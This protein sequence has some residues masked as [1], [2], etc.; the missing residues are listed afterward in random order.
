MKYIYHHLG[1]GDHIINNGMVRH[2]YKEYGAITLF[3]YKHNVKNVQYM[4]RDLQNFQ[5][6][7][8]ESDYQAD[9]YISKND[10]DCLKIGFSDLS[11]VMPELPF[12]KAF[13]KLAGLDFS[14]R[15]DEFYFE[16]DLE[17]EKEVLN[18]LNPTGEKFVF[19]HDDSDRG[20]SIDMNKVKTDYKIVMNDKRFN[21][22]DYI[23]LIEN[24]EE[25][26]FMQ[27]SFKELMCSYK[28]EKPTL[29]QHNYVRNYGPEMNSTGLNPF[30]EV[31]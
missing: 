1:L 31:E 11:D 15:F 14:V 8:I 28:L 29:Y 23:T 2:F 19:V 22:F 4:Y 24:A 30:V 12:D 10:L 3:S 18:T 21:V 20:F 26:H 27:S 6:I 13:Y 7:G 25:I 17:K 16:R 9:T 5:V